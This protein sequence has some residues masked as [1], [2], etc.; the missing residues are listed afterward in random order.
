MPKPE[1]KSGADTDGTLGKTGLE[2]VGLC[3]LKGAMDLPLW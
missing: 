2:L 1:A 3:W